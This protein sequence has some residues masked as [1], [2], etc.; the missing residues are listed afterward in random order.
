ML[1]MEHPDGGGPTARMSPT[2]KHRLGASDHCSF[3]KEILSRPQTFLA[4]HPFG[5]TPMKPAGF[6]RH[7]AVAHKRLRDLH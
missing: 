1:W 6:G 5:H 2:L 4:V 3:A 7:I